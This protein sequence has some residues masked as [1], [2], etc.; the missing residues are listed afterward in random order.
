MPKFHTFDMPFNPSFRDY[1]SQEK[2]SYSIVLRM[3]DKL[4]GDKK[5]ALYWQVFPNS[6]QGFEIDALATPWSI[7]VPGMNRFYMAESHLP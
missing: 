2:L 4:L 1:L 3:T 7:P 6:A 5:Y